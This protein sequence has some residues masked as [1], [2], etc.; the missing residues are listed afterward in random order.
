[1]THRG[2][3]TEFELT[4][5]ARI[6]QLGYTY[7]HGPD[8][9]RPFEEVVLQ[10][11]L[12]AELARRYPDLPSSALDE[13]VRRFARPEGVDTLRRNRNFHR[14]LTR[15][16]DD[17]RVEYE[18]GPNKGRIEHRH[19]HAI[20]W[21]DPENNDFL[22]VNQFTVHGQNTRRP[23]IVLF[24][25][26]LPL[27]V[28]ELKNPYDEHPTVEQA[29]TQIQHYKIDI[30]QL[31]E[32]NAVTVISD[33]PKTH[34]GVWT[35]SWEWFAPW[36]SIDG[37]AVEPETVG[38][39]KTLVEGLLPKERLL[40]YLRHFIVFES[41]GDK[42]T[43]KG[44]KYHQFFAVR[45]AAEKTLATAAENEK[46]IGVIWHTTGSGKSLSM[47]FLVGLLRRRPELENP[48]FVL[49]VDS[50]DLDDQLHDQ[51]VVARDLVGAVKQANS[52]DDL[53]ELLKTEGGEVI[54]TT[55]EK[56]RL[57]TDAE[58]NLEIE[59]PVL[60]ERRNVIVIADEAHR[61]QYGFK[62]GYARYLADAL[63]NAMRLG[64]TGT[65]ISFSGADTIEV[66]GQMIHT[67][68]IKQS[69]EDGMTVRIFYDPRQV[70]LRLNEDDIDAALGE[71]TSGVPEAELARRKTRWAALAKAAGA[72]DRLNTLARDLLDHFL[73]LTATLEGKAMIVCMTR[74]N[75]VRLYEALTALSGCPEVAVVMTGDI[76]KDP[77]EWNEA[78][79]ISTK[80]KREAIKKRMVDPD[81]PLKIVIVC[82]M[83]L[84]GTDIPCLHTLYVDKPMKGHNMIQAISRV[85]R[86][87]GDKPHGLVVDYIGIGDELREATA[88]YAR[89]DGRG[90]PAPEISQ[91]AKPVFLE[92]LQ[93]I[94]G[95]LPEGPDYGDWRRLSGIEMEDR[96][97]LVFGHL[98]EEGVER[99]KHFL[100]VEHR[101]SNA[102]LLVKHLDDCRPHADEMIFIQRVRKQLTK[103]VVPEGPKV[104]QE[105]E[106]AV[107][108]LVDDS[109]ESEGVVD[110][111]ELA[112]V[113]RA[114]IS[115]LDDE[116]LQ[117]FKDRPLPNLRLKLLEKI[118]RAEIKKRRPRNLAK[119]ESFRKLLEETLARYHKRLIDA[120]A[121]VQAMI[122][123]R[124]EM[125]SDDRRAEDI[126]LEPEE[127]A[128]YDAVA[129]RLDDIYDQPFLKDLIHDIVQTIKKNLKVDWT[130]SHR[131]DIRAGIRAAVKR[132]LRAKKVK[133]ETFDFI[134]PKVMEQAEAMYK[135]W[136]VAV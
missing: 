64:F 52:V 17:L 39:M 133:A 130:A 74:E 84:T 108:D 135:D 62:A 40:D 13:A 67:Y 41:A 121:V 12:R 53:R 46:R 27:V 107:R 82:D 48:T 86:V 19:V 94:R 20:D 81:D 110:I 115:I 50:T 65:P 44:A 136:P 32:F 23:D 38:S 18:G 10:D 22:V 104:E 116:F 43:K 105:L 91:S 98:T 131:E 45:I 119:A 78:G 106:K 24:I 6:E 83:W 26:G 99:D 132:V 34:H 8:L 90:E 70:K 96:Y 9:D 3:E 61:S 113:E 102:Y 92:L 95:I 54:F 2:T 77:P 25:N 101:L 71:V 112:G 126:G 37:E 85:N 125:E 80:M 16:I 117:T 59:H 97:S 49:E 66:F 129:S 35:A 11:R 21:D 58:G 42:I 76:S 57:K 123:I 89:G 103:A 87:F 5:I 122:E 100:A 47:A 120:A 79:H 111:F 114:D 128:F 88:T 118:V 29:F 72:V 73:E 33:G 7:I 134:I 124:K 31:F 4:T 63:P 127:L 55:I 56:F 30:P 60:S 1:M 69:Q 109:V 75:C 51:F 93:E 28:F 14:L 36:K 15:G 68:D